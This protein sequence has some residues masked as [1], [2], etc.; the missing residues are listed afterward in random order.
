VTVTSH[1]SEATLLGYAAGTLPFGVSLAVA[2]HCGM[3]TCCRLAVGQWETAAGAMLE[4]LPGAESPDD[5]LAR[6]LARLDSPAREN[7][8]SPAQQHSL[9]GIDLPPA[10][11]RAN[12]R[13][14]I[15]IAPGIW[16][17]NIGTRTGAYGHAYLLRL[18]AG[19]AIPRHGHSAPE[20]ICV[21]KGSFSDA[22]GAYGIG[23]FVEIDAAVDHRPVAGAE[24][25]CI[26]IVASEGPPRMRGWLGPLLRPFLRE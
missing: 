21:L 4:G 14:R 11:K 15:W 3:C 9:T 2:S 7:S 10:L 12:I 16:K 24:G 25:E 1:P 20:A 5:A 19:R 22:S 26:C 8:P 23:D 18:G 6:T 17:A 13:K